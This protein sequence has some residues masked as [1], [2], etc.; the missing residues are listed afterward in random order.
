MMK[1]VTYKKWTKLRQFLMWLLRSLARLLGKP[2]I[3]SATFPLVISEAIP[4]D[5]FEDIF[6]DIKDIDKI[7]FEI[8]RH[9]APATTS[10]NY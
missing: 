7:R 4:E 1:E 8:A 2:K 10:H 6:I 9:C 3:D 5:D